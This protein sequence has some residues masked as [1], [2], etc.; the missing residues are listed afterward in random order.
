ML[1]LG[2]RPTFS[3]YEVVM[4]A[5]LFDVQADFYGDLVTLEFVARLRDV[6]RF[7]GPDELRQ[8]VAQDEVDARR[9]LTMWLHP[10]NMDSFTRNHT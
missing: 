10:N 9:A 2:P 1:H 8:A 3:E 7:D 5:N 6:L 4:E